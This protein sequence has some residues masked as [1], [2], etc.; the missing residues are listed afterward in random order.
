M[1]FPGH[2]LLTRR[3]QQLALSAFISMCECKWLVTE[4]NTDL[5]R[6]R[7]QPSAWRAQ[8]RAQEFSSGGA[9]LGQSKMLRGH[10][11]GKAI[12]LIS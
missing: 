11:M 5:V 9:K 1:C 3:L 4:R 12:M 2:R 10:F 6:P 8:W 7:P